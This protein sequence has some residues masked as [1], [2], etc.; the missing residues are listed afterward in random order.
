METIESVSKR[1]IT[2]TLVLT[3]TVF[4][5]SSIGIFF[6]FSHYWSRKVGS[7]AVIAFEMAIFTFIPLWSARI[8]KVP[9]TE[10]A[11]WLEAYKASPES[12]LLH[13]ND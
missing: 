10:Q 12:H 5:I 2:R 8:A 6:T 7:L 4:T 13:L 9:K 11:Q 1:D 3:L